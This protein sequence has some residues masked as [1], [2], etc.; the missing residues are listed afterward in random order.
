MLKL[1]ELAPLIIGKPIKS[2]NIN[3]MKLELKRALLHLAICI[4]IIAISMKTRIVWPLFYILIAGLILSLISLKYK[5]PIISFFLKNFERQANMK[6]F[7]G[8]GAL[9]LIAGCLLA[10][11]LFPDNIAFASIAILAFGDTTSRLISGN[12][13]KKLIKNKNIFGVLLGIIIS[14]AAASF[15]VGLLFAFIASAIALIAEI[16]II[17]LG[18]DPVDD[19]TIVPLIAGTVLYLMINFIAL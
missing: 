16:L 7:P 8:K 9:F 11:K 10:L 15:F 19:N 4:A 17:K 3:K 1:F 13:N 12:I 5:I 14:S 6:T 2:I 18:E